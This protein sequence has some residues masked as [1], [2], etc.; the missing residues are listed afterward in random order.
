MSAGRHKLTYEDFVA[1]ARATHGSTYDYPE[2]GE[3]LGARTKMLIICRE[4]GEFRQDA[5]NH[6][7]GNGCPK[8]ARIASVEASRAQRKGRTVG[9]R[10]TPQEPFGALGGLYKLPFWG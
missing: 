2:H 7:A 3:Y 10:W 8:C 6:V 1:R 9:V 5:S 4:H